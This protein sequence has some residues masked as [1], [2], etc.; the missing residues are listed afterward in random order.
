[1]KRGMR[2]AWLAL[3]FAVALTAAFC[4][5]PARWVIAWIP[6]SSPV[7]ITDATVTLWE[8]S[9]T[10]AVGIGGLRRSL[11]DPPLWHLSFK[12]G[13]HLVLAHTWLRGPLKVA[14]SWQRLHMSVPERLLPAA[15]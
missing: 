1:M 11:P 15:V 12:G 2:T 9:A 3:L 14:L 10:M 4:L 7:L 8:A 6:D 5:L 13:P